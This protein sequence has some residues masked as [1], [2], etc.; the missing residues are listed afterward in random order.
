MNSSSGNPVFKNHTLSSLLHDNFLKDLF[1]AAGIT[2]LFPAS[3]GRR[4]GWQEAQMG[5]T[6]A[7]P[8]PGWQSTTN[9]YPCSFLY[10]ILGQG[11]AK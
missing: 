11:L 2:L 7:L 9:L 10:V 1:H 5:R 8:L 6:Q 4:E 3:A